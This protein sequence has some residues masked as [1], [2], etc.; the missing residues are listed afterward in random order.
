MTIKYQK[1]KTLVTEENKNTEK[2]CDI[3]A[4]GK[5][6]KLLICKNNEQHV[7]HY[8]KN[9]KQKVCMLCGEQ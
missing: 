9:T 3:H 2:Q 8:Y 1:T 4:V 6:S 7:V 5:R